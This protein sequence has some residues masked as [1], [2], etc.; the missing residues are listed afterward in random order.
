MT[1]NRTIASVETDDFV[2][3]AE[4]AQ[5]W[6]VGEDTARVA[7]RSFE[8]AAARGSGMPFPPKDP[9]FAHKRYWPAVRLFMAARAGISV[10]APHAADGEENFNAAPTHHGR[11]R[12]RV[13]QTR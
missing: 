7:I 13:A 3:D 11:A 4:I 8:A 6:R 2:S 9:L 5:R 12:H 1:R 10:G